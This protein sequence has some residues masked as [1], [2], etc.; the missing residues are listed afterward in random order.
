MKIVLASQSPRRVEILR[1]IGID[2]EVR[3][4]DV[5][6]RSRP[7]ES[8]AALT[9]RLARAKAEA[10]VR[11]G[12]TA[13]VVGGDTV[14]V[15]RGQMLG[16]PHDGDD[17]H[18]MLERMAGE[19]HEVVTG[20]AV[21]SGDET[22]AEVVRTTVRMRSFGRRVIEEYVATGEPMDKAGAYGIQ[23]RGAA[24]VESI[25]GD[26][27]SVVGFPVGAFLTLLSRAGWSVSFDGELRPLP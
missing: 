5:D 8:P 18:A 6:E 9:E 13:L 24:L 15:H 11:S 19:T 27:Y 10:G 14:V 4:V 2:P 7:G 25:S 23:G 16:K 1:Q 12:E 26:Y 22:V 20:I 21:A 3:P 17:A